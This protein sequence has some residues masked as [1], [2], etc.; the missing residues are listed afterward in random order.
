M[1]DERVYIGPNSRFTGLYRPIFTKR[2]VYIGPFPEVTSKAQIPTGL[3]RPNKR[4]YIGPST[5]NTG[6][7]RTK[8]TIHGSISTHFRFF[9]G[10]NRPSPKIKSLMISPLHVISR[11][12]M[13]ARSEDAMCSFSATRWP[14][15]P[16]FVGATS[17]HRCAGGRRRLLADSLREPR[18][19]AK[20][21]RTIS[22]LEISQYSYKG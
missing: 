3:Y 13:T 15:D 4:V 10:L 12:P 9:T 18:E 14:F 11:R 16:F 17:H 2:R 5:Q 8:T 6:L 22:L 20:C 1:N 7:Y 19:R 21:P